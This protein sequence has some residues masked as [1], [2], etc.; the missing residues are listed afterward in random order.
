MPRSV[1]AD[2]EDV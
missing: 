2:L 1:K